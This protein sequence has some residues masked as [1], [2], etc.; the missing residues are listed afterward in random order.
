MASSQP[1]RQLVASLKDTREK[2]VTASE[3]QVR[4]TEI[5]GCCTMVYLL[6]LITYTTTPTG[7]M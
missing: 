3:G 6:S 4:E 2:L 5:A 1:E 7:T